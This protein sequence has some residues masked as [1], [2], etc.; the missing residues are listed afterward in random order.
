MSENYALPFLPKLSEEDVKEADRLRNTDVPDKSGVKIVE[1]ISAAPIFAFFKGAKDGEIDISRSIV[2]CRYTD[3]GKIKSPSGDLIPASEFEKLRDGVFLGDTSIDVMSKVLNASE[4]KKWKGDNSYKPSHMF[5]TMLVERMCFDK[6]DKYGKNRRMTYT[7]EDADKFTKV[8]RVLTSESSEG[9]VSLTKTKVK[10]AMDLFRCRF[11][12][13]P[14][15]EFNNHYT[16]FAVRSASLAQIFLCSLHGKLAGTERENIRRRHISQSLHK[17]LIHQ[18][19]L[20]H[21]ISHPMA[22]KEWSMAR[23]NDKHKVLGNGDQGPTVDCAL[24]VMAVSLFLANKM[25]L[26]LLGKTDQEK[27]Q[28]GI[29]M[30]RRTALS[31][32]RD[33][34]MF[35]VPENTSLWIKQDKQDSEVIDLLYPSDEDTERGIGNGECGIIGDTTSNIVRATE[36]GSVLAENVTSSNHFATAV[37][38]PNHLMEFQKFL[39]FVEPN[40]TRAV[41]A[42]IFYGHGGE[43]FKDS[44]LIYV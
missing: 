20:R 19:F 10:G 25:P 38:S 26:G 17:W 23:V 29:E 6:G 12:I 32:Y 14:V 33:K 34:D 2:E 27:I 43:S 11:L 35:V 28:A 9:R 41:A 15:N 30:R 4:L 36:A 16:L 8:R 3:H 24:H 1:P 5:N 37:D 21:G 22:G 31:I 18:H 7:P 40:V 44:V 39:D 42:E 13:F